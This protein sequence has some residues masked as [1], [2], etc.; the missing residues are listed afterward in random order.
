[1]SCVA[2]VAALST[3]SPEVGKGIRLPAQWKIR[4]K[5]KNKAVL[6]IRDVYPGS[7]SNNLSF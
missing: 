4:Y 2:P 5:K 1:M 6:W 7:A 3:T